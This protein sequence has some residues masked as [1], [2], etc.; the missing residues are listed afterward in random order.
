[1]RPGS[2]IPSVDTVKLGKTFKNMG[3]LLAKTVKKSFF[4]KIKLAGLLIKKRALFSSKICI[5]F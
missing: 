3:H 4:S 2:K 5:A 1:M